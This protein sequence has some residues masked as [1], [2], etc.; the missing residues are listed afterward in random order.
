MRAY[1][2]E[3]PVL[4]FLLPQW[5]DSSPDERMTNDKHFF[6]SVVRPQE[7]IEFVNY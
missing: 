4:Q 5:L 6:I 2:V 7:K 1:W 3:N